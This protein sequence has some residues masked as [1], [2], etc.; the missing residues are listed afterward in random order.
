MYAFLGEKYCFKL[1]GPGPSGI[2]TQCQSGN[3]TLW[4]QTPLESARGIG[5]LTTLRTDKGVVI[6]NQQHQDRDNSSFEW[7]PERNHFKT[8]MCLNSTALVTRLALIQDSSCPTVTFE[9]L[10]YPY[11]HAYMSFEIPHGYRDNL[12]KWNPS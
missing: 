4:R 3:Q 2:C 6:P 5:K 11:R 12:I 9:S 8:G 10:F 1:I 7:P